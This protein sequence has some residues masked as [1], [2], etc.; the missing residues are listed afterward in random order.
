M[1]TSKHRGRLIWLLVVVLG[2][3]MAAAPA[4][5]V[6]VAIV[7][8]FQGPA[9][10]LPV[11][12]ELNEHWDRYGDIRVEID[13][14]LQSVTSFTYQDLVDTGA[15]VLW[16]SNPAGANEQYSNDE[17]AA[18]A[19]YANEGHHVFG[20]FRVFRFELIDNRKLAPVFGLP[21]IS[22]NISSVT[23]NLNFTL[24][25]EEH[26]VLRD[27]P[28][29][30][31]TGGFN[32]AQ[33]PNDDSAW[34][35]GD[36]GDAMLLAITPDKRGIITIHETE[37]YHA[38][39]V[40][41]FVEF[42]SDPV[43]AADT[44]FIYNALTL[45]AAPTGECCVGDGACEVVEEADC[46]T[47]DW[48]VGGTCDPNPCPQ[49]GACCAIGDECTVVFEAECATG[50]WIE[51]LDCETDSDDDGVIDACD[52]CPVVS[53]E[54]QADDDA[55]EIGDACDN[56]P[57]AFNPDQVDS[58]SDGV[59]DACDNCP[60]ISNPL[61]PYSLGDSEGDCAIELNLVNDDGNWQ[62]DREC[63]GAGDGCDNCPFAF[64]PKQEDSV[65]DGIGDACRGDRDSDGVPDEEDNCP[66]VPNPVE[67]YKPG[68][69]AEE[70]AVDRELI[71]NEGFWQPDFDCDGV[72]DP[73]DGCPQDPDKMEPGTC[74]CGFPDV[75]SDGDGV[76][77]CMDE[78]PDTPAE[79]IVG[80]DGCRA[81]GACCFPDLQVCFADVY[82]PDC[83]LI[84]GNFQGI[85]LACDGDEDGD[86][87]F[88]CDDLCPLDANKSE[89]GQC[90]CGEPDT[91]SDGD[92][93][94]D[95]ADGCPLDPEKREPGVCGCGVSDVDS[96]SDGVPDCLDGCPGDSDKTEPGACGCGV[97]DVDSD[98]DG[99]PDCLDGCPLDPD[100]FEPGL[101]GCGEPDTD[102]DG[103]GV[104]DCIDGCPFDAEKIDPGDCGCGLP[105][106]TE[107][108]DGDGVINCLDLCPGTPPETEVDEHGCSIR[109]ACC[110]RSGLATGFAAFGAQDGSLPGE[111]EGFTLLGCGGLPLK[112]YNSESR[113]RRVASEA[114]LSTDCGLQVTS[115]DT[116]VCVNNTRFSE[117]VAVDGRYQGNGSFCSQ[118]CAF[119]NNGDIDGN[120]RLDLRDWPR[121]VHCLAGP[122]VP[123][124]SGNC[125]TYDFDTSNTVDLRDV[126]AFL[127]GLGPIVTE[128]ETIAA[129]DCG[130]SVPLSGEGDFDFDN[131]EAT[132]SGPE[133][134]GCVFFGEDEIDHDVW[135]CWTAPCNGTVFVQTCG[136]TEVDTKLAVYSGCACPPTDERL[137][138][139]NDDACSGESTQSL[140]TFEAVAGQS[141]LVRMG[142]FPGEPGGTGAV[143]IT[144]G[145]SDCPGEGACFSANGTPGCEDE[146]CCET[147]CAVDPFCCESEWDGACALMAE[148]LCSGSFSA[149][150]DES[151]SCSDPA[152]NGTPGCEDE[153]C[154]NRVCQR[155]PFCCLQAW[156]AFCAFQESELCHLACEAGAGIC[157]AIHEGPGCDDEACCAEVC[158]RDPLCCQETWDESCVDLANQH[159]P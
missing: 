129:D 101:C 120:D 34:D 14:S 128:P 122:N 25:D 141:Y 83:E 99:V 42:V 95:C 71:D 12:A 73:C 127:N 110:F 37:S 4:L 149:C 113:E 58:D 66:E 108:D 47:G 9:E 55:D 6:K 132:T 112:A 36:L 21:E 44:Q 139:C 153:E 48:S 134:T 114:M 145:L 98:V 96:D 88:G 159:C 92:G 15:D 57:T 93:A 1:V 143:R 60:S 24:L 5:A 80:P 68:D 30:Y 13:R 78:C 32:R 33:V 61:V 45:G 19:Q 94:A 11:I 76:L 105:E 38:V 86:G 91:D 116:S 144:C 64:N 140:V 70:C 17:V 107:D 97:P 121:F 137:L 69:S 52:N 151:G 50:R 118:G 75:D 119:P 90:G 158:P 126:A 84:A 29:P 26:P 7:R 22:Y 28:S 155:D 2:P 136:L 150:G 103:D 16:I 115:A 43:E 49:V 40:S 39:Y 130:G 131:S 77:D 31:I 63:D 85:G 20:T 8:S 106:D 41:I 125:D 18:I 62:P 111:A 51:G 27:L 133:H 82:P 135:A 146:S 54:D 65:G 79:E 81:L 152:G 102:S 142:T 53:N 10:G 67:L 3:G 147:T 59:G 154:C 117:C 123:L 124:G 89:P 157:H 87:V 74:G 156:D 100:K 104:A 56:C 109:G 72:G 23:S 35:A 148:G 46:L 138:G